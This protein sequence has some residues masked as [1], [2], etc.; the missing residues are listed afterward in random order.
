MLY[1]VFLRRPRD[2]GDLRSDPFWEFGS[3]GQ[4]GCHGKNLLHPTR[5]PLRNGDRLVFLQG[6]DQEIRVVGMTPPIT[7]M[8]SQQR[9]DVRWDRTYRPLPYSEAPVLIDNEG[10]S[11]FP[12]IK[13]I[14]DDVDRSTYC[15]KAGSCLR[16]RTRPVDGG[17]GT[18][19]V[20]WFDKPDLLRIN[21]YLEAVDHRESPWSCRGRRERWADFDRRAQLFAELSGVL[22]SP[23]TGSPDSSPRSRRSACGRNEGRK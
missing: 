14:L 21:D 16:S 11:D 22:P 19:L 6:G 5:T 1:F 12:L 2:A 9:F 10:K 18:S 3:F 13:G 23:P 7:V 15:G 17:L 8:G 4:T 20:T